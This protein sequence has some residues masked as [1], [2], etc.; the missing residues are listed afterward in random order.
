VSGRNLLWRRMVVDSIRSDPQWKDGNYTQ[1]PPNWIMGFNVLR[2]MIDSAPDL[3]RTIPDNDA[4]D[5]FLANNRVAA[6]HVDAN[7]ILYSLKS[8]F[9]YNPEPDLGKIKTKLFALNFSDDEFNP[10]SLH[11][12][13]TVVPKLK[14]GRYV[15]QAGT[16]SSPG[17][18][19]MTRPDLWAQHVGE[20]M[21]WLGDKPA[22]SQQ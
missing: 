12:L 14:Q 22:A 7:D 8:S 1:T 3:Q 18:F 10:D 5:K 20:F 13:E 2:M 11:V 19:T 21:Q 17:H 15:V 9:S 16:A 4:A 6:D